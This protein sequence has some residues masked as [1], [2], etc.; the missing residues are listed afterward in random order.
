MKKRIQTH[1]F[2]TL[3]KDMPTSITKLLKFPCTLL[4]HVSFIRNL[5]F[6]GA[7]YIFFPLFGAGLVDLVILKTGKNLFDLIIRICP[8]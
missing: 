1:D 7:V 3:L 2:A 6:W 5:F 8:T 4:P